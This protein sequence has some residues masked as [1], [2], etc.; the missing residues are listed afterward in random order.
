MASKKFGKEMKHLEDNMKM[1]ACYR[2]FRSDSANCKNCLAKL[3]C[4]SAT[5]TAVGVMEE[6]SFEEILIEELKEKFQFARSKQGESCNCYWFEFG[7]IP[8]QI[9]IAK[10]GNMKIRIGY[11]NNNKVYETKKD[12]VEE[13]DSFVKQLMDDS[14]E[15]GTAHANKGI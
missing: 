1:G 2:H 7:P 8:I 12:S 9:W 6:Q 15:F 5:A 4:R 13:I 11:E 10:S 14:K 3:L